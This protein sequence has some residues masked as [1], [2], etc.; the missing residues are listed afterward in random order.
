MLGDH[1][2]MIEAARYFECQSSQSTDRQPRYDRA[3]ILNSKAGLLDTALDLASRQ[4]TFEIN[5]LSTQLIECFF[6]RTDQHEA[7]LELARRLDN[8]SNPASLQRCA[9][10]LALHKH[11]DA[12]VDLL[13]M[14]GKVEMQKSY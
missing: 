6:F 8:T 3:V 14:A 13:A 11:Y 9:N 4:S 12:A 2:E 1:E 10:Y 5:K 7:V